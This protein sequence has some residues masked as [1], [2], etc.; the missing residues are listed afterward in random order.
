[1]RAAAS[2]RKSGGFTT[3]RAATNTGSATMHCGL[4]SLDGIVAASQAST[5]T[6]CLPASMRCTT[7]PVRRRPPDLST[8]GAASRRVSQALPS[9]QV[10][11]PSRSPASSPG[12]WKP[13]RLAK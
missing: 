10:S 7:R 2:R 6:P 11:T 3:T 4:P 9:G 1:V 12:A 13:W 8:S 5:V